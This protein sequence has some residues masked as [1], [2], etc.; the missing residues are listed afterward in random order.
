M[1][2][3][4]TKENDG[5]V[6]KYLDGVENEGKR[7][8][9]YTLLQLMEKITGE[10]PKMWGTS[11]IGYGQ[12]HYKYATGREGDWFRVGFSPRKQNISLYLMCGVEENKDLLQK[13]G[14]YKTGKSCLYVNK[15]A[16]VNM[17]VLE[18]LIKKSLTQL[19]KQY[20]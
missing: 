9:S 13:L 17:Q 2:E 8:D 4:K 5:S 16:D 15:L 18:Q 6:T 7:K 10:Q 12:Y 3:L 20:G 19:K 11:I 14:K 1:A